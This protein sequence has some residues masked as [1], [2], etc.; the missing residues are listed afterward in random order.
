MWNSA[1]VAL[2]KTTGSYR[3]MNALRAHAVRKGLE[4]RQRLLREGHRDLWAW[5]CPSPCRERVSIPFAVQLLETTQ[6]RGSIASPEDKDIYI[7]RLER[8]S[9][10]LSGVERVGTSQCPASMRFMNQSE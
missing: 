10:D 6:K 9:G 7:F 3:Q 2:L 4:R 8:D 5:D 1:F